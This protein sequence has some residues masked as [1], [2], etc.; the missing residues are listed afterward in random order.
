MERRRFLVKT[1]G[2]LA[3]AGAAAATIDAPNVIAQPK[4][5]WKMVTTWPPSTEQPSASPSSATT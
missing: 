3:A 4:F 2:V 1:G 5:Q